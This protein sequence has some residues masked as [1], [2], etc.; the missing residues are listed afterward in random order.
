MSLYKRKDSPHWWIKLSHDGRAIQRSTGTADRKKAREYHDKLKAEQWDLAR[1]G[2]KPSRMWEEAVLPW[3][4]EKSHKASIED[5]RRNFRWLHSH[6]SGVAVDRIDRNRVDEITLA[7]KSGGV[8]NGTVNRTLALLRAVLRSAVHD[9]E[10]IERTPRVRLLPEAKGRVRYL[11]Q[12]EAIKL[13]R[14][15]PPHL[16]GMAK[17][18][19][20]TGLR[21][22]NVRELRWSQVDLDRGHVW[23]HAEDAKARKGI[24]TPLTGEAVEVVRAQAGKH[25]EFVFTYRGEP[26]RWVNNSG[27][28][29]ALRRAGIQNFRWHDLRHTWATMH[30]VAETPLHVLQQLGGWSSAQ[31]TQR[32]AHLTPGHLASHVKAFGERVNLGRYDLATQKE[33]QSS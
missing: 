9:W 30:M 26:V 12:A 19:M 25:A 8:S 20:L 5:D 21:Q 11:S 33:G 31:M 2:G 6:L 10:W 3:L 29:S 7:R 32:Y 13:L 16:A 14:E 15:L 22:R 4:S 24:A 17:F 27:W 1:L 28:K 23:I 18:S